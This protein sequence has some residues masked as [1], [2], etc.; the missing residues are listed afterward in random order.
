MLSI[1]PYLQR[2]RGEVGGLSGVL[3]KGLNKGAN[4]N[5]VPLEI[6]MK[7]KDY[8]EDLKAKYEA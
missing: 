1:E 8:A 7:E 6:L 5:D 3:L 4:D 2:N